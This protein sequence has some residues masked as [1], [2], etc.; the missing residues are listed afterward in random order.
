MPFTVAFSNA[1]TI[2]CSRELLLYT[3]QMLSVSLCLRVIL[4][5]AL[6]VYILFQMSVAQ[7][8]VIG[9]LDRKCSS[10]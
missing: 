8:A 10:Q 5:N 4:L 1:L 7:A 9:S 6:L 3:G 2:V